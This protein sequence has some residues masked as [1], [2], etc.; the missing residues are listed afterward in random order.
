MNK[1]FIV[2]G[3]VV[4]LGI[5]LF[6]WGL[7]GDTAS[8]S[9]PLPKEVVSVVDGKQI[10]EMKAKAGYFPMKVTAKAGMPTILRVH[11]SGTYDCSSALRVPSMN[12]S[13]NLPP[14]GTTDIDLGSPSAGKL[15]GTCSMGMYPFEIDFQ[16]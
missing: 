1:M 7:K 6:W 12:I 14:T 9:A 2:F 16:E 4:V 5:T 3:I 10:I 8:V 11:T 15:D 13:K